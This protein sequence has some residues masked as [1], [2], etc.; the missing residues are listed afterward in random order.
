MDKPG[1]NEI[2][3]AKSFN[4]LDQNIE[5]YKGFTDKHVEETTTREENGEDIAKKLRLVEPSL[6]DTKKAKEETVKSFT[7]DAQRVIDE[8]QEDQSGL[9]NLADDMNQDLEQKGEMESQNVNTI[10][11]AFGAADAAGFHREI[12]SDFVNQNKE[13]INQIREY[14]KQI[15]ETTNRMVESNNEAFNK[16]NNAVKGIS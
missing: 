2:N 3:E 12:L 13:N 11:S 14:Q 16:L 8:Q 15:I 7:N 6:E 4:D 10:H 9:E 5:K 1:R